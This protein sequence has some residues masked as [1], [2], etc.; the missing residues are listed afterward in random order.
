M[1]VGQKRLPWLR[2]LSS[3]P[4]PGEGSSVLHRQ[5]EG[6]APPQ[7]NSAEYNSHQPGVSGNAL[8]QLQTMQTLVQPELSQLHEKT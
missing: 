1:T 4:L 7:T 2:D 8:S 5:E 3:A 6:A